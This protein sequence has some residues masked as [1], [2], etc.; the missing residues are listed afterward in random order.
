MSKSSSWIA[1]GLI[2]GPSSHYIDHLTPLCEILDI[3]LFVTDEEDEKIVKLFYP[4]V[5]VLQVD[6]IQ[7]P[8]LLVENIDI[9]F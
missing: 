9:V 6:Y 1:A 7:L 5:N 3:P 4:K 2:Y 8:D